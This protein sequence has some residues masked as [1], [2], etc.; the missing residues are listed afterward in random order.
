MPPPPLIQPE[1]HYYEILGQ[2]YAASDAE[3]RKAYRRLALK[4]H[5]DK[6]ADEEGAMA[7]ADKFA[8]VQRAYAVLSDRARR[9]AY[10]DLITA[11]WKVEMGEDPDGE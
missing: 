8:L 3:L 4:L 9:Q 5:P 6:Q 2:S 11:A 1:H 7:A 10:N